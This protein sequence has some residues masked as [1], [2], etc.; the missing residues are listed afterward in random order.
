MEPLVI[1]YLL[2][3][4]SKFPLLALEHIIK[5]VDLLLKDGV[6]LLHLIQPT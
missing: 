6:L 5:V 1:E 4:I 3:H 2:N